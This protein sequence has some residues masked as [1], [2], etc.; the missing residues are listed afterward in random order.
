MSAL[1]CPECEHPLSSH[2]L[3]GCA[4]FS[5]EHRPCKLR[6]NCKHTEL[7]ANRAAQRALAKHRLKEMGAEYLRLKGDFRLAESM[8]VIG[9]DERVR[10]MGVFLSDIKLQRYKICGYVQAMIDTG[11]LGNK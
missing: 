5:N 11:I 9:D 7:Q 1:N 6:C 8:R 3:L 10:Y 4:D 2:G